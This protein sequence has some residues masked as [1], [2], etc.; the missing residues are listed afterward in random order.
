MAISH[1]SAVLQTE[2]IPIDNPT[3]HTNGRFT[4]MKSNLHFTKIEEDKVLFKNHDDMEETYVRIDE[5]ALSKN[6]AIGDYV[7]EDEEIVFEEH[8]QLYYE[9]L[10]LMGE[11][12]LDNV[13]TVEALITFYG[14]YEYTNSYFDLMLIE[15]E[16]Y[17]GFYDEPMG[18]FPGAEGMYDVNFPTVNSRRGH[19][20]D[21]IGPV[22]E[23]NIYTIQTSYD[24]ENFTERQ[25]FRISE[26]VIYAA[27]FDTGEFVH[28]YERVKE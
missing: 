20:E 7:Y 4:P 23:D 9:F 6:Y 13:S 27:D 1:D 3:L 5:E 15:E 8:Y 26:D 12:E 16:S 28:R 2:V 11:R 25:Y 14:S 17:L 18:T 24:G 22:F 19:Q 10:V 21:F